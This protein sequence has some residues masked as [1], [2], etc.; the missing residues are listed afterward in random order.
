MGSEPLPL[1]GLQMSA[2]IGADEN[3]ELKRSEREWFMN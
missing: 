3:A 1:P 2:Q